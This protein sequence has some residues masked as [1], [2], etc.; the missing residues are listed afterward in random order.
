ML[1]HVTTEKYRPK[2]C[3]FFLDIF[4]KK[5]DPDDKYSILVYHFETIVTDTQ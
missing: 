4:G 2:T 3:G 1:Q 5:D